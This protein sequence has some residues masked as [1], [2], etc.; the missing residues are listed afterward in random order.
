[1]APADFFSLTRRRILHGLAALPLGPLLAGCSSDLP[2]VS[3]PAGPPWATGG[4]AAMR[5]GYRDPFADGPG[6][7]CALTCSA[8]LGPCYARTEVRRD[9]SEGHTGLPT[10]LAFRIVDEACR[11]LPNASVDVWH[12]APEG[13]YSGEDADDFCTGE[14]KAARAARWFRGVQPT[15]ANGRADLDTCFPGWYPGRA[16]HIHLTVRVGDVD[17]VTTQLYFD[18]VLCDQILTSQPFYAERGPRDTRNTSDGLIAPDA[19]AAYSFQTERTPEGALLAWKT[20]VVRTSAPTS[21][22]VPGPRRSGR[23]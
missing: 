3:A 14:D 4:T 16:V 21:C 20:L 5:G 15:D 13:T 10:R 8:I 17:S 18:D 11:P 12:A 9:M 1:M 23:G 22:E 7:T 2:P 6:A 19:V